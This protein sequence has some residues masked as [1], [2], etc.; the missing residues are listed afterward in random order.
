MRVVVTGSSGLIGRALCALLGGHSHD[1]VRVVR[2][3]V[4]PGEL[5]LRW[6]PEAGTIDSGGLE[7]VDAVVHLAGAGIGDSRWSDARKRILVESRTR[8]TALLAGALA[9]LDR[10]PRVL[11]SASAI[12]FYGD[13]GD[14]ILTEQSPP[15]DDFLASLCARWEAESAPAA[16]AG[17]RVACARTGVVLSRQGGALPKLLR[18]FK[19]GLGGRFGSGAQWWSWIT[20]DDEVRAIEWLLENDVRGPVNLTAPNPVTNREFTRVLSAVLSR[21]AWLP[22]PRFGPR[23]LLGSE[24]ADS[25]LFTSARV[26]PAVLQSSG[27][28]FSHS[29]L[30]GTLRSILN[31]P[32]S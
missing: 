6:D 11:V 1:V 27:F 5:A 20:L 30:E 3:P 23:L 2:R 24:L 28:T 7:G 13:R 9:E 8:S 17:I 26:R 22:V 14:E 19:L 15:A 10:Q 31:P 12:G 32:A 21:P 18:L 29:D 4:R 25:L 16:E